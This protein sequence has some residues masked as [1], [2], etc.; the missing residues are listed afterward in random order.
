MKKFLVLVAVL[1]TFCQLDLQA[2]G[3]GGGGRGRLA[4]LSVEERG[5]L[6]AA[7]QQ[8]MRDPALRASRERFRAAR[9][10]F[11]EKLRQGILSA[12]PSVQPILEKIK[13]PAGEKN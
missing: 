7:H 1:T 12:D 5:R 6:R 11:Q 3:R 2:Q 13:T 10:E 8:A 4:G 9:R